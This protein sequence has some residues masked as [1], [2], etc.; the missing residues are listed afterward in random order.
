MHLFDLTPKQ[1]RSVYSRSLGN[2]PHKWDPLKSETWKHIMHPEINMFHSF[3][4]NQ[5]CSRCS[6]WV[7]LAKKWA[8][9]FATK[10]TKWLCRLLATSHAFINHV[11]AFHMATDLKYH[12]VHTCWSKVRS[13]CGVN[14]GAPILVAPNS[15]PILCKHYL[16]NPDLIQFTDMWLQC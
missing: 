2:L 9:D 4:P 8:I 6:K 5:A 16:V 11:K 3:A 13:A 1:C 7:R 14:L 12:W 10:V 15:I